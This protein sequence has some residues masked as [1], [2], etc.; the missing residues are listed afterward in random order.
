MHAFLVKVSA[1]TGVSIINRLSFHLL[2]DK[3]MHARLPLVA[4]ILLAGSLGLVALDPPNR[5]PVNAL[6]R[7][8]PKKYE[9]AYTITLQTVAHPADLA[10]RGIFRFDEAPVVF[11]I[12]YMGQYSRSFVDPQPTGEMFHDGQLVNPQYLNMGQEENKPFN[13]HLL[14]MVS[15][16]FQGVA[17]QFGFKF[18]TQSWNALINEQAA[19]QATWP[20]DM[21]WPDEVL[22]GLRPQTMIESDHS[23]FREALNSIS[24]PE[25]RQSMSPYMVAK[26]VIAYVL[27]NFQV[28]GQGVTRG[29]LGE[30]KGLNM[31]GALATT[32]NRDALNRIIGS[33]H[34]LVCVCVAMLRAANIPARPVIGAVEEMRPGG[35]TTPTI[36]SWAE[37]YLPESGWVSFDPNAMRGNGAGRYQ[38][39]NASWPDFGTMDNLNERVVLSYHFIPPAAVVVPGYYALWGWDPRPLEQPSYEQAIK[40]QITGRGKGEEDPG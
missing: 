18:Q 21:K 31:Q 16:R 38:N 26:A 14:R 28:N 1:P 24:T 10:Q 17:L 27:N 2:R 25:Q 37:F 6:R 34:D 30:I 8:E 32:N 7:A 4:A 35:K 33:E 36:I 19:Q 20:R 11:P 40:I 5:P 12:I 3:I 13:T 22:D 9:I 39:F 23:I 15:P 29:G